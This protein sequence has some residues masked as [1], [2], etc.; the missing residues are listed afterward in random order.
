MASLALRNITKT[1]DRRTTAVSDLSLDVRDGEFLVIVGPSGCGK[2]T[3]LRLIAGLETPT[4]G[5]IRLGERVVN[6]VPPSE[7]NV[8]MVFQDGVL[9]PHLSVYANL[10]F[11]LR[12]R[13]RPPAEV[14]R[15][16]EEV[17]EMLG[18]AGLARRK[19]AALSGGQRQRV[20]L[21]RAIVRE[22]AVFL[23]DEPL[24][25]LDAELR[26]TLRQ[27]MKALHH[28]LR[29]T[30]LY[31]THDQSEA[32]ALGERVCVL[33]AGRIQQVG[34][35]SEV[36]DRPANRFVAGF[37]GTPPMNFLNGRLRADHGTRV[38]DWPG[39]KVP[40]PSSPGGPED[41]PVEVGVRPHDL[42]LEPP[43]QPGE[44]VLSGRIC[45][46][47]PFGVRT[48]VHVLLPGGE[49]CVVCAPPSLR[50]EGGQEIRLY[51]RPQKLHLFNGDGDALGTP[52]GLAGPEGPASERARPRIQN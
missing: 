7:R 39:G 42:L 31:V 50:F 49:R 10:A 6:Q 29:T 47:E 16:V 12:M 37:F 44:S 17:I 8:A 11:A 34:R 35:P 4:A 41:Q 13:R 45:L 40:W 15:R 20:A 38:L 21:G 46:W 30:T 18:L 43:A 19:P 51:V 52:G 23:F 36:Y 5:E 32:M 24:S 25:S 33:R 14:R 26:L 28:R 9:Y 2:T 48:D 27:E 1:F 3:I 22:P